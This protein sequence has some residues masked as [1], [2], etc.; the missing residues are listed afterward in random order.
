MSAPTHITHIGL[1]QA[2]CNSK[3][4]NHFLNHK[5]LIRILGDEDLKYLTLSSDSLYFT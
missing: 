5:K 4:N 3:V 2:I 1:L